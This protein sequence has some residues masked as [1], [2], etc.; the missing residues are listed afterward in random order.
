M[1]LFR[2]II[3]SL[4]I[5]L[6]MISLVDLLLTYLFDVEI[7]YGILIWVWLPIFIISLFILLVSK[8]KFFVSLFFGIELIALISYQMLHFKFHRRKQIDHTNYSID[9]YRGGYKIVE[10]YFIIE[11]TVAK[12][13]SSIFFTENSKTA[14]VSW[15]TVKVL[16][17]TETDL[18][19]EII[20]GV[21]KERDTLTKRKFWE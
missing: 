19:I 7:V 15:F 9:A 13:S 11:K 10:S 8:L 3:F 4:S 16:R 12:K 14:V 20:S 6:P 21:D 1:R 18:E 2:T 5:F 17:E